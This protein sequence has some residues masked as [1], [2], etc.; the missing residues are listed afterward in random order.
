MYDYDQRTRFSGLLNT[1]LKIKVVVR[2]LIL[3]Y[4]QFYFMKEKVFIWVNIDV[5]VYNNSFKLMVV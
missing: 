1:H 3:T 2:T 5:N 4:K